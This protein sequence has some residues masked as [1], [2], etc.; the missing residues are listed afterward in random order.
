MT[1]GPTNYFLLTYDLATRAVEIEEW[2]D[3]VEG[4][5][6]R[7][8]ERERELQDRDDIEV[9]LVGADSLDTVK[10]THSH[11]FVK[12]TG[13]LFEQLARELLAHAARN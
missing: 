10:V 9:V 1:T 6:A 13:D 7:Y 2:H 3:D 11:Y 4:A 8:S 5:A 12:T